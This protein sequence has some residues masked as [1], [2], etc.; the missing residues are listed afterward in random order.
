[1][2]FFCSSSSQPNLIQAAN[3]DWSS[4]GWFPKAF[5]VAFRS[6]SCVCH[7]VTSVRWGQWFIPFSKLIV[8]F[9][10][11]E[12]HMPRSEPSSSLIFPWDHS[13]APPSLWL[14]QYPSLLGGSPFWFF[15]Q[16]A[17][18]LFIPPCDILPVTPCMSGPGG[19]DR[20]AGL[21]QSRSHAVSRRKGRFSPASVLGVWRLPWQQLLLPPLSQDCCRWGGRAGCQQTPSH[22]LS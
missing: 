21:P 6:V 12:S 16:K 13:Q 1:M 10:V 7:S 19:Q 15:G 8:Y 11:S 2:I 18:A 3:S 5:V 22:F 20:A 9:L 14:S 4:E 17:G